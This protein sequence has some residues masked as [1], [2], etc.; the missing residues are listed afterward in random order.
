MR[1][2]GSGWQGHTDLGSGL[3]AAHPPTNLPRAYHHCAIARQKE[4]T[5]PG[6][7]LADSPKNA[8]KPASTAATIFFIYG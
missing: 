4:K 3:K 8:L 5:T 2:P 6:A 1:L 7:E